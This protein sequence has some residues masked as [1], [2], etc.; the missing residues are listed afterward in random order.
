MKVSNRAVIVPL[1]LLNLNRLAQYFALIA[2]EC[3]SKDTE[4]SEQKN[5]SLSLA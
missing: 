5:Y 4:L 3:T 2:G 1:L